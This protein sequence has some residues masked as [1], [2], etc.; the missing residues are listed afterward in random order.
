M[1][2]SNLTRQHRLLSAPLMGVLV[3]SWCL[4]L[5]TMPLQA[6]VLEVPHHHAG[7]PVGA[8]E[9]MPPCHGDKGAAHAGATEATPVDHDC[10]NCAAEPESATSASVPAMIFYT[11]DWM[12][13]L[14]APAV[15][16][17]SSAPL[18]PDTHPPPARLHLLKAVFLI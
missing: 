4:L 6:A 12:Q 2:L 17:A 13:S 15:T 9:A 10:V 8:Q 16:V 18:P 1:I 3:V 11:L 14:T 7:E 5:C